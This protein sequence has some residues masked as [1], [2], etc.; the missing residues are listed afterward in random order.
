MPLSDIKVLEFGQIAAG[1]FAG[2]LLADLGADVVKVE[3]PDGGDGMRLWPPL[4]KGENKTEFSENFASLNRNKRSVAIDLKKPS[5]IKILKELISVCD[6]LIE[7]YRPGV[8][9][10]LNLGYDTLKKINSSLIYC[11]ISGYGQIGP[12]AKKGAFDVTVQ[13]FS[14]LMSVTGNENSEPVKCGVPFGDFCAGLYA[15]YS[16]L[17]KIIHK[18]SIGGR[19][20]FIDCSMLGSLIGVSALQTS[21]YFGT[22]LSPK[23][24]GS[25]HP[26]N[27]PYRAF[28]AKDN[29]FIIAAGNDKL[30]LEVVDAV[31]LSKLKNDKRFKTQQLR[32][33]HQEKLFELLQPEFEKKEAKYWIFEMDRRG[34][35]CSLIN[36]YSDVIKENQ[37]KEMELVLPLELPNGKQ[38]K[39]TAF[40]IKISDYKFNIYRPPPNLGNDNNEIIS[41]WLKKD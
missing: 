17:A 40:P 14:G 18:N 29:H 22:G 28:K 37:V 36:K 39:T 12:N 8:M 10:K 9:D 6:V 24:M 32:A 19:G 7:N 27:A 34:V 2:S 33:K 1:P 25:A 16:I 26:R 11:S 21:E 30:W 13:A 3:N 23:A 5:D 41:D 38:T 4:S 20:G 35:P 31:K 15:S